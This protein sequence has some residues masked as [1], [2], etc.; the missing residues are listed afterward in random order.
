MF[1]KIKIYTLPWKVIGFTKL[2]GKV[3]FDLGNISIWI[4]WSKK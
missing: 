4:I 2:K 3:V 1:P